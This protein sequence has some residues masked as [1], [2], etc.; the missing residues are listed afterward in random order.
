[1][2]R[3]KTPQEQLETMLNELAREHR[4]W[5]A[6]RDCGCN[7]PF[8]ADGTNMNLTRNHIIHDRNR[9]KELCDE[10]GL[11]LPAEWYLPIPPEVDNDYMANFDQE[12]R[13]EN[14]R[15]MDRHLTHKKPDSTDQ[16]KIF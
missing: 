6:I 7:D 12:K 15:R 14:L 13:V 1:M 4:H 16:L 8:W 9:I 2:K 3:N 11:T 5:E 10:N